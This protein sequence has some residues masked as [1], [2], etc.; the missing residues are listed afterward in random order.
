MNVGTKFQVP[1]TEKALGKFHVISSPFWFLNV[2]YIPCRNKAHQTLHI[3][4]TFPSFSSHSV[5]IWT[6]NFGQ[7]TVSGSD[8]CH[9]WA[10]A[11]KT[12]VLPPHLSAFAEE[13]LFQMVQPQGP[14]RP[15]PGPECLC[16]AECSVN[17]HY[18]CF[19]FIAAVADFNLTNTHAFTLRTL[20]LQLAKWSREN[21]S[22]HK[23]LK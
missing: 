7:W 16:G 22:F 18:T 14:E 3:L 4:S 8:M 12:R 19:R 5:E 11:I 6:P 2:L 21:S 15:S 23:S 10:E 17:L 9:F 1:D 20:L 13:H